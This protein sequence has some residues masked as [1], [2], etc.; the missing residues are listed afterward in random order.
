MERFLAFVEVAALWA[1]S[2]ALFRAL[3][4]GVS[5]IDGWQRDVFGQPFLTAL[6]AFIALPLLVLLATR[7]S[8]TNYGLAF[9]PL[10]RLLETGCLAL[11]GLCFRC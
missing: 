8:C 5:A 7:R 2:L 11:A 10:T 9:V 3:R 6:L 1:S 4:R